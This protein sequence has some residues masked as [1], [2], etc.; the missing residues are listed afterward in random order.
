MDCRAKAVFLR[1]LH[2]FSDS[3]ERIGLGLVDQNA[4]RIRAVKFVD[5]CVMRMRHH[6]RIDDIGNT[7]AVREERQSHFVPSR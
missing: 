6:H 1:I 7:E 3:K 4:L 5:V 2:I